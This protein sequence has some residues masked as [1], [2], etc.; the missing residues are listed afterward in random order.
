MQNR[1]TC[2]A[3]LSNGP[4]QSYNHHKHWGTNPT[5]SHEVQDSCLRLGSFKVSE[6][7]HVMKQLLCMWIKMWAHI[8]PTLV[9][10]TWSNTA[11]VKVN[12]SLAGRTTTET[13]H[14]IVPKINEEQRAHII[15]MLYSCIY[16]TCILHCFNQLNLFFLIFYLVKY[17]VHG[18]FEKIYYMKVNFGNSA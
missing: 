10:K 8:S 16:L 11:K 18:L 6:K 2:F 15:N 13:K 12:Y 7:L 17:G 4:C 5:V 3:V 9:D 1:D 14:V